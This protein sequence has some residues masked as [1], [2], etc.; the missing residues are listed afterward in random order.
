MII[1]GLFYTKEHEWAK[2]DGDTVTVGIT[3]YAQE[4][5]GEITFV[6]LPEIGKEIE[7]KGELAVVESSKAASDVYS[8]VTGTVTQVN[9]LLESTPEQINEDC[10]KAGWICIM[11]ITDKSTTNNL[12]DSKQYEGYLKGP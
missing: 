11:K 10:Y 5:L 9:T 12:M 3:H 1:E 7:Q 6:E 8:P 2:I 4:M